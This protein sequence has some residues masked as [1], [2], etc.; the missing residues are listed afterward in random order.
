MIGN[1]Y[2]ILSS[3]GSV[4]PLLELQ[5]RQPELEEEKGDAQSAEIAEKREKCD[6]EGQLN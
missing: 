3:I 4:P 6:R 5:H 1:P 2:F